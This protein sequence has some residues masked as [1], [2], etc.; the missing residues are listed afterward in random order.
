MNESVIGRLD[1]LF[2][3]SPILRAV[4][5]PN[6]DEIDDASLELGVAFPASYREFLQR[7]GGA[8][9]GPYP[10]F[11]LRP[12]HVFDDNHWSVVDV[13]HEYRNAGIPEISRWVVFSLDHAGNPIGFDDAG[14]IWLFDHDFD[15]VTLLNSDF[16]AYINASLDADGI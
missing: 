2:D 8:M 16:D 14:Q 4:E 12:V 7:Y 3:E 15:G 13:T 9:V 10:I 5:T 1:R 6:L 11:G